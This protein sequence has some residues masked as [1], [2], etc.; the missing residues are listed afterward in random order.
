MT[1][2]LFKL[3]LILLFM[4]GLPFWS[5]AQDSGVP[6]DPAIPDIRQT[7]G[8]FTIQFVPGKKESVLSVKVAGKAGLD[9]NFDKLAVTATVAG[10]KDPLMV[11]PKGD[12]K[13]LIRTQKFKKIQLKIK[14]GE[15]EEHFPLELR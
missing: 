2:K 7:R 5:Q 3:H 1:W 13:Y 6:H 9:V 15:T 4:L 10:R 11:I 8:L 14:S 12:Q